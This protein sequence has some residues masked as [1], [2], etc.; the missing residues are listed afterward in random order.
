MLVISY[1]DSHQ[2]TEVAWCVGVFG[3]V[4]ITG[5]DYI[6]VHGEVSCRFLSS[7]FNFVS[8]PST[9]SFVHVAHRMMDPS[10]DARPMCND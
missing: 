8:L 9:S 1:C 2:G 5:T 4:R 3:V 6:D 7:T 10:V